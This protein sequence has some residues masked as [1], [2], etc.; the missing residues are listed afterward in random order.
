MKAKR[1]T[2]NDTTG[3]RGIA[4]TIVSVLA[5]GL[6]VIIA[7]FP[8]GCANQGRGPS[9]TGA[10]PTT[11]AAAA[12]V[13]EVATGIKASA[14]KIDEQ[15][16]L[17][18]EKAPDVAPESAAIGEE[19]TKLRA[20]EARLLDAG[21][22]LTEQQTRINTLAAKVTDL[23]NDVKKRDEMIARREAEIAQ[24]KAE[25]ES[26]RVS[27]IRWMLGLLAVAAVAG[28]VASVWLLRSVKLAGLCGTLFAA[29]VGGM[30]LL[31]WAK[32]FALGLAAV[33]I[34]LSVWAV[35][36]LV[37]A[38]KE[39]VVTAEKFKSLPPD[40]RGEMSDWAKQ[41]QNPFTQSLVASVREKAKKAAKA[42]EAFGG[43][44]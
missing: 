24:I 16:A 4:W 3:M 10:K 28:A 40:A 38:N 13:G 31:A 15:R 20:M 7:A 19:T 5:L 35:Y 37:V 8:A 25:E 29:A 9:T 27:L 39:I 23:E 11:K 1:I 41:F 33:L 21:K 34:G 17:A 42:A 43:V 44:R 2:I 14:D 6:L 26:K 36:R 22:D 30:Y 18:E 32:W 12:T